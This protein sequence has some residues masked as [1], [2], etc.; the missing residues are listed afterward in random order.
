MRGLKKEMR[1]VRCNAPLALIIRII[2]LITVGQIIS[3]SNAKDEQNTN[4]NVVNGACER[5]K[6]LS[7]TSIKR[8]ASKVVLTLIDNQKIFYVLCPHLVN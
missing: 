7:G 3:A 8:S 6:P 4:N 2:E 5:D 1:I